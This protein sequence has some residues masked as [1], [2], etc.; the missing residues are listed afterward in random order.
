MAPC[1]RG[2]ARQRT[3]RTAARA[4]AC[5]RPRVPGLISVSGPGRIPL[6]PALARTICHLLSPMT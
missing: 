3:G 1:Y 4:A 6:S 5:A 2:L